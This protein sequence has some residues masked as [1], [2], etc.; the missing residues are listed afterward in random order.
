MRIQFRSDYSS[1]YR[2][3][4]AK[5]SFIEFAPPTTIPPTI[6]TRSPREVLNDEVSLAKKKLVDWFLGLRRKGTQTKKWGHE[7]PRIAVALFLA[8]QDIFHTGNRTMYDMNYELTI[9][10]LSKLQG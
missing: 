2:G 9:Q 8:D 5:Y 10:L 7:L 6:V 3:F 1:T 4:S